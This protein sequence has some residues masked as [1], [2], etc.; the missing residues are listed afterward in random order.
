MKIHLIQTIVQRKRF[1]AVMK[2]KS[3]CLQLLFSESSYLPQLDGSSLPSSQS[4]CLSQTWL[5]SMQ[6]DVLLAHLNEVGVHL[7][8]D[9]KERGI[10]SFVWNRMLI[11]IK[12][13]IEYQNAF[14]ITPLPV[15]LPPTKLLWLSIL[16]AISFIGVISAIIIPVTLLN[17][18]NAFPILTS[19]LLRTASS[20][21]THSCWFVFTILTITFSVTEPRVVNAFTINLAFVVVVQAGLGG[22]FYCCY[23]RSCSSQGCRY[24]C[25]FRSGGLAL[26]SR[27]H[28]TWNEMDLLKDLSISGVIAWITH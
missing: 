12:Y 1:W 14:T 4:F 20:L 22:G 28:C 27:S 2:L 19:H 25:Y 13:Q 5:A 10:R 21:F 26:G 6:I 23:F 9:S 17:L 16:T 3:K 11:K 8:F 24:C 18:G 7:C 15:S